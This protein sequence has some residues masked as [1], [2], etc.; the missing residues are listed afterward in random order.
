LGLV[1]G[2]RAPTANREVEIIW[3]EWLISADKVSALIEINTI[4]RERIRG[5]QCQ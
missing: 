2:P 4:A 1:D 5:K 3:K